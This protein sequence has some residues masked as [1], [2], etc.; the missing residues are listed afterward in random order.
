MKHKFIFYL[1]FLFI[2]VS[3]SFFLFSQFLRKR[4]D[5]FSMNPTKADLF[6]LFLLIKIHLVSLWWRSESSTFLRCFSQTYHLFLVVEDS[7]VFAQPWKNCSL[8]KKI[9]LVASK[10]HHRAIRSEIYF[11]KSCSLCY[12]KF[13][14]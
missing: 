13:W 3:F 14:I 10:S 11:P 8:E 1:F 6:F 5:V 4:N 7:M 9:L 12:W 2:L